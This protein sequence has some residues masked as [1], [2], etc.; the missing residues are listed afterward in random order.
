MRLVWIELVLIGCR[1][2]WLNT[3]CCVMSDW[4]LVLFSVPN[5]LFGKYVN[6]C[7]RLKILMWIFFQC[8][9]IGKKWTVLCV[10]KLNSYCAN[11]SYSSNLKLKAISIQPKISKISGGKSNSLWE[12][13][14]HYRIPPLFWKFRKMLFHSSLRFSG[15]SNRKFHRME[16][17]AIIDSICYVTCR[18]DYISF[19]DV[20]KLMI[21]N[22]PRS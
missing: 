16:G 21:L 4:F 13:S 2:P 8:G 22:L 6:G 5:V 18:V 1:I 11:N 15:N 17:A 12:I 3:L 14:E 7:F 10:E 20:T 19:S 9:H